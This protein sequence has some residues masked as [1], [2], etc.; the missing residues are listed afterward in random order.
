MAQDQRIGSELGGYR[1]ESLIGRGGMGIVY[2]AEDATLGRKVAIKL[3]APELAEDEGFRERFL[4]ESRLAA[5]LEHPNIITI[6]EAR[7]VDGSL[8]LAMRYVEGTDLRALIAQGGA[9]P[10]ER[11]MSIVSQVASALD[12]AHESGLIHRDVKPGNVLIAPPSAPGRPDRVYLSDF[13]LTKRAASDSGMTGTGQFVG[14]LEYAAPEQFEGKPLDA[15]TDVYSLGCVLYEC[16]T[17]RPPFQRENEAALVYAHL[18]TSP[19]RL[20]EI[21]PD[22]PPAM[23]DVLARALAKSPGDRFSS[24]SEFVAA[25][26]ATLGVRMDGS[27]A[28][29]ASGAGTSVANIG[30]PSSGRRRTGLIAAGGAILTAGVIVAVVLSLASGSSRK[31]PP[32]AAPVTGDRLDRI[33]PRTNSVTGKISIPGNPSAVATGEGSVWVTTDKGSLSRIDARTEKV[34]A[35]IAI[36]NHPD[37]LV[38][39]EGAVWIATRA[40]TLAKVDPTSNKV[41]ATIPLGGVLESLATGEGAVWA[42]AADGRV[43]RI[44]PVTAGIDFTAR[45]APKSTGDIGIAVSVG[46]GA[47]WVARSYAFSDPNSGISQL[48]ITATTEEVFRLAPDTGAVQGSLRLVKTAV[49]GRVGVGAIAVTPSGLWAAD[50]FQRKVYR[51]APEALAIAE[52]IPHVGVYPSAIAIEEGG[53]LWVAS[54]TDG[55][56]FRIVPATNEVLRTIPVGAFA[57]GVAVGEGAVWV[58]VDVP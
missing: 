8:Y 40:G 47:V 46:Q 51:L 14:T 1:I 57:K 49:N 12:S 48:P 32:A 37:A 55:T 6:Y 2:L 45:V 28:G 22:L 18:L 4:R 26:A 3:L 21:R 27:T 35:M 11:A 17:G 44:D 16:L 13:G 5:S 50:P 23:D 42:A 53:D 39:G 38:V 24:C 34:T 36:G 15:R 41:V 10:I 58:A 30:K 43:Y 29:A 19:P 54:S 33:D 7:Q 56:L 31:A 25:A 52:E 9:L 20:T